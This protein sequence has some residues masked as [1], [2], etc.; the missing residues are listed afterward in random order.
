[1]YRA[2]TR[3]VDKI[4]MLRF[5]LGLLLVSGGAFG[6]SPTWDDPRLT[7]VKGE[8]Q[9]TWA[10]AARDG[11]PETLLEDKLH[12]GL[13]KSVPAARLAQV[14]AAFE[15]SLAEAVKLSKLQNPPPALLKA[16]VEAKNAGAQPRDLELVLH[17]ANPRGA[18]MTLRA[19]DVIT[20]L[21]Q[22]GFPPAP[23]ARAVAT[24]VEKNPRGLEQIP[25]AAQQATRAKA[26]ATE[27]LDAIAR[28]ADKGLGPDHALEMLGKTPPG[29]DDRGPNRE[30]SGQ[31]GVNHGKGKL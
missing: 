11:V 17:A 28:A 14:L 25:A 19:I 2:A 16:L 4:T 29:Q 26:T 24:V 1:M 7:A 6:A 12:E 13:A 18:A 22:R 20:D 31:R 27:A 15:V 8:L 23:A 3:V 5:V 10:L 30:T 9:A 21:S